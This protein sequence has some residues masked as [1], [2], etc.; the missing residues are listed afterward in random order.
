MASIMSLPIPAKDCPE[1]HKD[2]LWEKST[3]LLNFRNVD[4]GACCYKELMKL[5]G[6]DDS[7]KIYSKFVQPLQIEALNPPGCKVEV[8]VGTEIPTE[9]FYKYTESLM[10]APMPINPPY[11]LQMPYGNNYDYPSLISFKQIPYPSSYS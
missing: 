8:L 10:D 1:E 11:A 7:W 4:Y 6:A 5:T 9:S 3:P 2:G